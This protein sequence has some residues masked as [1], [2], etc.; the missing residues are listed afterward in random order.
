[1]R[2]E[3]RFATSKDGTRVPY[4]VVW[5]KGATADGNNPTL[6][7]GYG[8]FEVSLQPQYSGALRHAPGTA[9]AACWWWPTSAAAASSA[10]PGTRPHCKATSG[11]RPTTTS[12]PWPRT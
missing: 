12:S 9:A 5:P 1:M 2:V 8:G 3:Q 6:L 7:Y 10:R 4:F 11:R